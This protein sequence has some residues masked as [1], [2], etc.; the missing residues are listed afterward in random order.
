ML[1]DWFTVGAQIVNFLILVWLLKRY[2]FAPIIKAIDAREKDIATRRETATAEQAKA[3][4]EQEGCLHEREKLEAN[5]TAIL[6]D[7]KSQAQTERT[8]LL[9]EATHAAD[10][11]RQRR[12]KDLQRET[13]EFQDDLIRLTTNEII[14]GSRKMVKDLASADL[15]AA[16]VEVFISR[17]PANS[18][19]ANS[20]Q[21]DGQP[22]QGPL[23]LNSSFPLLPIQEKALESQIQASFHTTRKVEFYVDPTLLWGLNLTV[24]DQK[25]SWNADDYL[26]SFAKDLNDLARK[27]LSVGVVQ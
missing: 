4:A 9:E 22:S 7:A 6:A 11:V 10:E 23:R 19:P 12:F 13:A 3:Q 18:G 21:P 2:L 20:D 17:L 5:R 8:K 26:R 25:I 16:L 1:I 24:G 27:K 14:A 15:A